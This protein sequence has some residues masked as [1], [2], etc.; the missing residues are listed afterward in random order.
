MKILETERLILRRWQK[1]DLEPMYEINQDK[2][3]M[4]YFPGLQNRVTTKQFIDKVVDHFD[5][6]DYTLYAV[7]TKS[8]NEFIG[9]IGLF[10]VSF[11]A[12][13]TPATE[14]GWRLSSK[15]WG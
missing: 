1:S 2:K 8:T 11:K 7:Q 6:Y 5:K 15:H 4:K 10:I 13:F 3:V 14:I 12:H 9:F